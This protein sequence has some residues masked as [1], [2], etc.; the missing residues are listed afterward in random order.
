MGPSTDFL[1]SFQQ[2]QIFPT[3]ALNP[4]P[5]WEVNF[6]LGVELTRSKNHLIAQMILG[7]RFDF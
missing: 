1:P 5:E 4:Y 6:G 2:Q 3:V 7:Y